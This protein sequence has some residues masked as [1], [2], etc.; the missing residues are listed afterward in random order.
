[1]RSRKPAHSDRESM[2]P[3]SPEELLAEGGDY[4]STE[5]NH[6]SSRLRSLSAEG[7]SQMRSTP[8][9]TVHVDE[10]R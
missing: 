2:E 7:A 10:R 8:I 6:G 3:P 4:R 5:P 9:E 1:M